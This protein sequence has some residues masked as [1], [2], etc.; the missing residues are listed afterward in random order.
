[1]DLSYDDGEESVDGY[2]LGALRHKESTQ[3]HDLGSCKKTALSIEPARR[4]SRLQTEQK[5]VAAISAQLEQ[6]AGWK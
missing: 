1:V 5:K 2:D 3:T 6:L 4:A